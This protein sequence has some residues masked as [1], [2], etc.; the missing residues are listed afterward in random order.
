[1][2]FIGIAIVVVAFS[3]CAGQQATRTADPEAASLA[4]PERVSGGD[5]LPVVRHLNLAIETQHDGKVTSQVKVCVKPSGDVASAKIVASSGL[6]SYDESVVNDAQAWK[7]E[8]FQA[9]ETTVV[10]QVVAVSYRQG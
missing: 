8:R 10:C 3:G 9:P 2:K 1:M 7:Y 4:F 5:T 6:A